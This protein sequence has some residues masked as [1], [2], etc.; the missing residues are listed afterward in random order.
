MHIHVCKYVLYE[1]GQ[2]HFK[3]HHL[4]KGIDALQ[5]VV[6]IL[7]Q[8]YCLLER[9]DGYFVHIYMYIFIWYALALLYTCYT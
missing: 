3:I 7:Y 2:Q 5:Q 1:C 8:N 4:V 6:V 9:T